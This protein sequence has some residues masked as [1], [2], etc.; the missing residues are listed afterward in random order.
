MI[1]VRESRSFL[2]FH[3]ISID[4]GRLTRPGRDTHVAKLGLDECISRDDL[5]PVVV[6]VG[7][8]L[9]HILDLD[10]RCRGSI[11]NVDVFIKVELHFLVTATNALVLDRTLAHPRLDGIAPGFTPVFFLVRAFPTARRFLLD[12]SVPSWQFYHSNYLD[13]RI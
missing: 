9:Q 11:C 2:F 5:A 4:H 13:A 10:A 3:E 7:W 1:H 6:L 8:I 12:R